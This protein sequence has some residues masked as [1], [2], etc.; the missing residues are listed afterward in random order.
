MGFLLSSA[1]LASFASSSRS[2]VVEQKAHPLGKKA[3][4]ILCRE[5]IKIYSAIWK[6]IIFN[7]L[8]SFPPVDRRNMSL[9]NL[10]FGQGKAILESEQVNSKA[11]SISRGLRIKAVEVCS[12]NFAKLVFMPANQEGDRERWTKLVSNK[13]NLETYYDKNYL[14]L[15]YL[16]K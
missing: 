11:F 6:N 1:L 5:Y 16:L 12:L 3:V 7:Y 9:H 13:E 14:S 10:P 4:E 15:F 8:I 2:V